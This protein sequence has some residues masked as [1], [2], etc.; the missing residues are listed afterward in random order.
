MS[1]L[2]CTPETLANKLN[3][4]HQQV[5]RD[6]AIP[7]DFALKHGLRSIDLREAKDFQ[8]RNKL[9]SP[10]P[11]LPMHPVTGMLIPYTKCLDGIPR[12]RVRSDTTEYVKPGPMDGSHHGEETVQVPRYICQANVGV[13]PYIT[14]EVFAVG[15]DTTTPLYV[16]EAPLKA[17]CLCAHGYL[18]I[19]L[20]GVIAGGHDPV[21]LGGL[22]EIVVHPELQRIRWKGRLVYVVFD[23]GVSDGD[24][25]GNPMVALGAAYVAKALGD[26]GA[27]VRLVRI[28]Y[29]HPQQSNPEEGRFWTATDQG[30][31]DYIARNGIELFKKLVDEAVVADPAARMQKAL[32]AVAAD[33]PTRK[34]KVAGDLLRALFFAATLHAGGDVTRA[35]V[36]AITSKVGIGK[37]ALKEA[38]DAFHARIVA[39]QKRD[40][41]TWVA[42]LATGASGLPRATRENVE[43]CLR[44]DSR[45]NGLLAFD[46]FSQ[47]VVFQKPPPWTD[48]YSA[49]RGTTEGTSWADD[50]DVRLAGYLTEKF[51]ILDLH[52]RKVRAAVNVVARDTTVHPVRKYLGGLS[53][54]GIARVDMW[55]TTYFGVADTPYARKVGRWWLISLVARI[56]KPGCKVDHTLI[57]EGDQGLAKS[58]GL[59]VLGGDYFS[60]GDLGDLR[61]KEAAMSLQGVW[62]IELA[63]G[64]VFSRATTRAL[65]AYVTKQFD[66]IIP[67]YSNTRV[68]LPRQCGFA[69]TLNDKSDYLTDTTGNRRFWPVFCSRIDLEGLASIRDQLWAEAVALYQEGA[70]WWPVSDEDKAL[71]QVEQ[72]E[73]Q[74][75]DAWEDRVRHGVQHV[76]HV[77]ISHVLGSILGLSADKVARRE[78][79]RAGACLRAIGWQEDTEKRT[80]TT[81]WWIRGSAAEPMAPEQVTAEELAEM[82]R[83]GEHL[84]VVPTDTSPGDDDGAAA[85]DEPEVLGSV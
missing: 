12:C 65:K 43:L 74:V 76:E 66:D 17:L 44:H 36:A 56:M 31:D 75:H 61:S 13:V 38:G 82:V 21:V 11:N 1:N 28:P 41:P 32:D 16:V 8:K 63:E 14:D 24:Q 55:L 5:L 27:D 58:S 26:L 7:I 84:R 48:R 39:R 77:S 85:D 34:P 78:Q 23:A 35:A 18:A 51:G 52:E 22:R 68:R 79:L 59:R 40:E 33:E 49:S 29:Y 6:R 72:K 37:R 67:K 50:D 45:L 60:D 10:W 62:I 46:E 47:I 30:P 9:D 20:G 83:K 81:R 3:S 42:E 73:R 57:L 54:D 2:N 80:G 25:P 53:W 71:C 70:A 69:L 64:E 4:E 15:G 19:G